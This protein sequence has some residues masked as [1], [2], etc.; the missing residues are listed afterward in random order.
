M[1]RRDRNICGEAFGNRVLIRRQEVRGKIL[2]V[3]LPRVLC[4]W[5]WDCLMIQ[6]FPLGWYGMEYFRGFLSLF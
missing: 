2:I 6:E 5:Y 4:S 3:D 1:K